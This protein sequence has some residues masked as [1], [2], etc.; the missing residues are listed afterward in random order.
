MAGGE[1]ALDP[2][3]MQEKAAK[4]GNMLVAAHVAAMVY[5]G[6][7]LGIYGAMGGAGPM[8]PATLAAATGLHERWLREWLQGQAAEGLIEYR[9]D[10]QFELSP[11]VGELLANEDSMAAMA[12]GFEALV[13]RVML[14]D[15]LRES[16]KTGVG[17]T[18]DDRGEASVRGMGRTFR[19]WYRNVLVPV[20]LPMLDGTVATLEAGGVAAD[21]GCGTGIALITLAKAF[22]RSR[23]HGY[24]IS[25]LAL[26]RARA[27]AAAAG[28]ANLTFHNARTRPLPGDGSYDLITTFDCVHDMTHPEEVGRAIRA[29]LKPDGVWFIADIDGGATFE[30]NLQKNPRAG[31]MYAVSVLACMSSGLSEPGGAGLG[32]L[33][34]PEPKMRALAEGGG[35]ARCRRVAIPSP[36]NAYYEARP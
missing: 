20:A 35:F 7:Q 18:F 19:N 24:D 2:V 25:A 10:G 16:F 1:A 30:E 36:V 27:D 5:L 8:T 33:G 28:L 17:L 6:D 22:P 9:G 4:L 32:T 13:Q 11:E 29:A 12:G 21:I 23:F 26:E 3:R 15:R 34:L 14:V 31:V